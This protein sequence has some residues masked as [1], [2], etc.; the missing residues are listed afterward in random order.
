VS[1]Y[2]ERKYIKIYKRRGVKKKTICVLLL[3]FFF[4]FIIFFYFSKTV[5]PIIYS[6]ASAEVNKIII[7]ASNEAISKVQSSYSY[8]DMISISY[9]KNNQVNFLSANTEKINEISCNLSNFTQN[10]LD[11]Y[12]SVGIDIP[13]GTCSGIGFLT[14]KGH[15]INFIANPI[16]DVFCKFQTVFESSGINQTCHKIYVTICSEITLTLPF[17]FINIEKDINFLI[18]ESIIIGE[19]PSTYLNLPELKTL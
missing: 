16:G 5:N 2:I 4:I 15:K 7:R 12:T 10:N 17:S 8:D 9:D 6:Y 14:G 1:E 3:L 18:A 19:I 11:K 13:I